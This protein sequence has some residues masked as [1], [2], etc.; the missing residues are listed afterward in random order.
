MKLIKSPKTNKWISY[1]GSNSGLCFTIS[2]DRFEEI[3]KTGKIP[4]VFK[5]TWKLKEYEYIEKLDITKDGIVVFIESRNL[6]P[7]NNK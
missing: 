3:L 2:F 1:K 6:M 7:V 4:E 5:H